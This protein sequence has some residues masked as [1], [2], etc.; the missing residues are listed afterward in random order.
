[1]NFLSTEGWSSRR[2]K[3]RHHSR[4]HRK[5]GALIAAVD[6]KIIPYALWVKA[7][8]RVDWRDCEFFGDAY[9][10]AIA[11]CD[12]NEFFTHQRP[13]AQANKTPQLLLLPPQA[14]GDYLLQFDMNL[15]CMHC[16]ISR[17]SFYP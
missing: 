12:T 2:K 3:I 14:K 4:R 13:P 5:L 17:G 8:N 6:H 1:M 15:F 9:L 16:D 11:H 7:E 10:D